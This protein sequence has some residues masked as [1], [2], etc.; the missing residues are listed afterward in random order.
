MDNTLI[1]D[2]DTHTEFPRLANGNL[3]TS[4]ASASSEEIK[5]EW[6]ILKMVESWWG[7]RMLKLSS[8]LDR[9]GHQQNIKTKQK[10]FSYTKDKVH[11]FKADKKTKNSW[12][13]K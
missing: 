10:L 5:W 11:L 4:K 6:Y 3:T 1:L 12:Q 2:G 7:V 13:N 9:N 8:N